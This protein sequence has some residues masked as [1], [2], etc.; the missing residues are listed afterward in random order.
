MKDQ[1]GSVEP[2]KF[3]DLVAAPGNPI[4]D[5]GVLEGV[6]FVMKEGVVYKLPAPPNQH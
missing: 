2:S 3:A 1:I 4:T 6:N 5:I